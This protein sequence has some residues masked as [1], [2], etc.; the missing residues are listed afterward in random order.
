MKT[1]SQSPLSEERGFTLI[2]AAVA[3]VLFVI[4]SISLLASYEVMMRAN[5]TNKNLN[6]AR[7]DARSLREVM[8][9]VPFD[10]IVEMFPEGSVVYEDLDDDSNVDV[11][12]DADGDGRLGDG[13][14]LDDDGSL[15]LFTEDRN[16]NGSVDEP[17]ASNLA[18]EE[19]IVSYRSAT[20]ANPLQ[21]RLTVS[22]ADFNMTKA[23]RDALEGDK[24]KYSL[25][26]ERTDY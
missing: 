20:T 9:R 1:C 24:G 13:E 19:I 25:E 26:F 2:E 15:D 18:Q 21:I 3:M 23:E 4:I 17:F 12:E 16:G 14:D 11:H 10:R 5:L 8:M 6:I 22:W 7:N